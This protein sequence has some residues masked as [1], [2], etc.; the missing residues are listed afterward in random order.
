ML[1]ALRP[2]SARCRSQF[3]EAEATSSPHLLVLSYGTAD[4]AGLPN[5]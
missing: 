2:D 3:T 5:T 4:M 1:L